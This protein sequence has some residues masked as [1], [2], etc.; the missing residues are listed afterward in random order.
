ME[1]EFVQLFPFSCNRENIQIHRQRKCVQITVFPASASV[2]YFAGHGN[3]KKK[4]K[5]KI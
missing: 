5:K 2:T 3:I 4:K 1:V